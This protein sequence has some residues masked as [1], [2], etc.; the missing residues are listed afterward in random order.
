MNPHRSASLDPCFDPDFSPSTYIVVYSL[1]VCLPPV[2][3]CAFSLCPK[4][5]LVRYLQ[6][7]LVFEKY[8]Q[9]NGLEKHFP[10]FG[11][12]HNSAPGE[13]V[14]EIYLYIKYP[15]LPERPREVRKLPKHRRCLTSSS[16]L[17]GPVGCENCLS[18]RDF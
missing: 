12:S 9:T 15:K 8:L 2:C 7:I 17:R 18:T 5:S 16:C 14:C 13:N 11:L 4:K 3:V 1:W 10:K 6:R